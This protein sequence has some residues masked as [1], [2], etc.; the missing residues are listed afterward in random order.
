MKSQKGTGN[1]LTKR[2]P[3]GKPVTP[4][5]FPRDEEEDTDVWQ[6]EQEDE[7][8]LIAERRRLSSPRLTSMPADEALQTNRKEFLGVKRKYIQPTADDEA[9]PSPLGA[10]PSPPD[11]VDQ[12]YESRS[13]GSLGKRRRKSR[14]TLVSSTGV[15]DQVLQPSFDKNLES[16]LLLELPLA[17]IPKLV[18]PAKAALIETLLSR[19]RLAFSK[20]DFA[21][22]KTFTRAAYAKALK[23][24]DQK[25]L[26][27]RCMFWKGICLYKDAKYDRA[28]ETF[29]EAKETFEK[30]N[31]G[32]ESRSTLCVESEDLPNWVELVRKKLREASQTQQRETESWKRKSAKDAT[33]MNEERTSWRET[34]FGKLIGRDRKKSKSPEETVEKDIPDTSSTNST[35]RRRKSK[36]PP[37]DLRPQIGSRELAD[38]VEQIVLDPAPERREELLQGA[39]DAHDTPS[40]LYPQFNN[41]TMIHIQPESPETS[42]LDSTIVRYQDSGT[43][44]IVKEV[45]QCTNCKSHCIDQRGDRGPS[46]TRFDTEQEPEEHRQPRTPDPSSATF[47]VFGFQSS[48]SSMEKAAIQRLQESKDAGKSPTNDEEVD[49]ERQPRNSRLDELAEHFEGMKEATY[50]E[51]GRERGRPRFSLAFL[52]AH[53]ER[54]T[55]ASMEKKRQQMNESLERRRRAAAVESFLG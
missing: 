29:K 18:E 31:M 17:D 10:S 41:L 3:D 35:T 30:V 36:P 6:D 44:D 49:S 2:W 21:E 43:D 52:R 38:A 33:Q 23:L 5:D 8:R 20:R 26:T 16:K 28:E 34:F 40:V 22:M 47:R 9:Q 27:A 25:D 53:A 37:L 55:K 48:S 39:V 7:R 32:L 19:A 45:D 50:E 12:E 14:L 46:I 42:R 13:S 11:I 1:E 51:T 4:G 54:S 24:E 15:R